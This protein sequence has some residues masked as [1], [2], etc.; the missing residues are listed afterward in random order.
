[1]LPVT[2]SRCGGCTVTPGVRPKLMPKFDVSVAVINSPP[3]RTK[4]CKFANPCQPSPGR[5]SSVESSLPMFGVLSVVFH[6]KGLPV[7]GMPSMICC[8]LLVP[9]GAKTI[10]S[11]LAFKS[12]VGWACCVL[13]YTYG[14]DC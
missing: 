4:L 9:T 1:M 5:M 7:I 8:G 10:T 3:L 13:L 2:R 14:H 12:E 11:Y 6:G